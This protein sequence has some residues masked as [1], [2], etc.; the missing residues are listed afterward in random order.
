MARPRCAFVPLPVWL[1]ALACVPCGF[2]ASAC[3]S[4]DGASP[5]NSASGGSSSSGGA[6]TS[7]SEPVTT[8]ET[9]G[10]VHSGSVHLGPVDFAETEWHNS[11]APYPNEVRG[12]TGS[13]IAGLDNSHNGDGSL[14]D[15][16]V[17]ITTDLGTSL[18]VHVV[19]TGVSKAPGDM[20][21]SPE[22]YDFLYAEDPNATPDNPRPMTWQLAKCPEQ[23]NI[24]LQYQE[25]A[26]PW[27]TSLWVRN[28]VLPFEKVEVRSKNHE[29]FFELRRETD[30]TLNDDGGFGEG[31]FELRFTAV[32]GQV[33]S[34]TFDAFAP[35]DLVD[36]GVQFE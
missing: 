17:L 8:A 31:P 14:C 10:D 13:Y 11:C 30:G 16:C 5:S 34:Q 33:I 22:A 28:S 35:G 7:P 15:A 24:Q 32:D 19:T 20:D 18:L 27:W 26:N 1:M 4:D 36:S 6:H 3:S 2:V 25:L 12:L 29:E 21:V 23:G 9:F